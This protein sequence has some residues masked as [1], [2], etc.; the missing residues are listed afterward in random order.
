MMSFWG[1][2][3]WGRIALGFRQIFFGTSEHN[4]GAGALKRPPA[5]Y[6]KLLYADTAL[7]G[8]IAATRCGHDFFGSDHCLFATD[9]PFDADRGNWLISGTIEAVGALETGASD[10]TRIR[11]DNAR[12]L[13]RLS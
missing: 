1:I 10:L 3:V 12:K 9:A 6:F 2:D 11:T 5:D 13:L 8:N 7:N 4:P